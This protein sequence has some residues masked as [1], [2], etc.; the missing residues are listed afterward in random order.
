MSYIKE[1]NTIEKLISLILSD[2]NNPNVKIQ[3]D[4]ENDISLVIYKK[5]QFLLHTKKDGNKPSF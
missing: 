4:M 3:Y 1:L 2:L 5:L